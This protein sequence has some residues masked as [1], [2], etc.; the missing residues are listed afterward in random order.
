MRW[1]WSDWSKNTWNTILIVV[2]F[3]LKFY[4]WEWDVTGN[5]Q[6]D[7][8]IGIILETLYI[9]IYD[10]L[11]LTLIQY[12]LL[13]LCLLISISLCQNNIVF[14][15]VYYCNWIFQCVYFSV[16]LLNIQDMM[17]YIYVYVCLISFVLLKWFH[18]E[19]YFLFKYLMLVI[20][21]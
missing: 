3:L 14:E 7:I 13:C 10:L 4:L 17:I 5:L 16:L 1:G 11:S 8:V 6:I 20:N 19:H 12:T 18:T 21:Y 9:S 15:L 2:L